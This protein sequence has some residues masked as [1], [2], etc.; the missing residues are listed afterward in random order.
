MNIEPNIKNRQFYLINNLDVMRGINTESVKVIATDPPFKTDKAWASTPSDM[1]SKRSPRFEDRWPWIVDLDATALWLQS[2]APGI[3]RFVEYAYEYW[4][5]SM[6]SFLT[7]MGVRAMEMHRILREDGTLYWHC[8][9]K[10]SHYVKIILDTVFGKDNFRNE[11]VWHYGKWPNSSRN[12]QNN[13]DIIL[14]YTKSDK[15]TF[16]PIY[17]PR[18]S[19]KVYHTN[20]VD[21]RTQLLIYDQSKIPERVLTRHS[22][23]GSTIVHVK[24]TGVPEHDVWTHL[25]NRELNYLNPNSKERVRFPTQ[26]PVALYKR[27]ICASSDEGDLILDPFAGC[28]T[29]AIAAEA[30]GRSWVGIDIWPDAHA[31]VVRRL[32][33]A[34]YS[35]SVDKLREAPTRS[36]G[37]LVTDKLIQAANELRRS[38]PGKPDSRETRKIKTDLLAGHSFFTCK[39]CNYRHPDAMATL[40]H[41][42]PLMHGGKTTL[43]NSRLLCLPC[44]ESKGSNLTI[45]AL[46]DFNKQHGLYFEPKTLPMTWEIE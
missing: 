43:E 11:I 36:D 8:D 25:R 28:A 20:T 44:N 37:V 5:E 34:G 13:H 10:A 42:R 7:Y 33:D 6:G 14:R 40:D 9:P 17:I 39:G 31:M 45:D 2:N 12:F 1:K 3:W 24:N 15:Y 29:S 41:D 16:N 26:K 27:L 32:K 46:I 30:S 4:G 38:G 19:E 23:A 35:V 21:G 22:E 18:Q